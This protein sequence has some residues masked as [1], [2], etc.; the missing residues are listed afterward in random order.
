MGMQKVNMVK[1]YQDVKLLVERVKKRLT[2]GPRGR[3]VL[4][5]ALFDSMLLIM[6]LLLVQNTELTVDSRQLGESIAR[7]EATA[8]Q[9]VQQFELTRE[10]FSRTLQAPTATPTPTVVLPSPTA[11]PASPTPTHTPVSP[12]PTRTA[13]PPTRTFTPV[14]PT[15]TSTPK[16]KPQPTAT[17]T[18]PARPTPP[19]PRDTPVPSFTPPGTLAP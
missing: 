17:Q 15:P 9:I 13:V 5:F 12:T 11:T 10:T 8:T 7:I 18:S 3:F 1:Y 16:E 2:P 19:V 6:L 14:P 4:L